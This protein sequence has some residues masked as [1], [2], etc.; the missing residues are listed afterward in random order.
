MCQ[1]RKW[2]WGLLPLLLLGILGIYWQQGDLEKD[3]TQRAAAALTQAGASWGKVEVA[4]RDAVLR[5]EALSPDARAQAVKVVEGVEGI[6]RVTDSTSLLAEAKPF[7]FSAQRD[8]AKVML[9]GFVPNAATRE[10]LEEAARK[11]VPGAQLIDET[12]L[13]RGAPADFS[14]L[15]GFGLGQLGQLSQGTLQVTDSNLSLSGRAASFEAFSSVRSALGSLPGGAKLAKGLGAGDILPPL[16]K[17][18]TFEAAREGTML[19][20]NG[21]VPSPEARLKLL[22][23]VKALGLNARDTLKIADGA[24]AG[25]WAGMV[26]VGLAALGKLEGGKLSAVDDKISLT[27]KAPLGLTQDSVK[28]AL[29]L[30]AGFSL[31]TLAIEEA[32]KPAPVPVAVA[33]SFSAEHA[34]GLITLKGLVPDEKAKTEIGA[35]AGRLF[36]GD[37]IDNQLGLGAVPRESMSLISGGLSLLSRLGPGASLSIEGNAVSLKGLAL[38]DAAR[39]SVIE[40]FK[41]LVPAGF[42]GSAEVGTAQAAPVSGSGQCQTLFNEVLATGTVRF[43]VASA[44]L[45]EESRGILDKLTAIA[46]RCGEVKIEIGGHTDSDGSEE[47]NASLSR[48]R[49]EAVAIYLTHGGIP[50]QRLAP[51]GYGETKPLAPNDSPENK[52]KNRRIEF[53]VK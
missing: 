19:T 5:G 7:A 39:D 4:G 53:I 28:A 18:F 16:V 2:L 32:P 41:R 10:A 30:P 49:A 25:D 46:L 35:L 20:L 51:V 40:E 43:R 47:A 23:Q 34:Q 44:Q 15:T 6:R 52:A 26:G 8:G 33:P 12:K 11:A 14:V 22:A 1:P 13:A 37:Q 48:L 3:L 21:Y 50:A 27:G 42:S 24:P 38:Y 9:S 31:A 36:Q 17:P 45:S 29:A